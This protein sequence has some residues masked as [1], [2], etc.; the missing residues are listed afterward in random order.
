MEFTHKYKKMPDDW[1]TAVLLDVIPCKLEDLSATFRN[2][3]TAIEGGGNY[4]L[5]K[6]GEYMILLL[7]SKDNRLWTTIR[8]YTPAKY[9]YYLSQIGNMLHCYLNKGKLNEGS[10][11]VHN[12]PK[13]FVKELDKWGTQS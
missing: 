8:R 3:D 5:P 6:K 9:D 7:L 4:P 2:Y 13:S 1:E 11:L 12:P 10:V